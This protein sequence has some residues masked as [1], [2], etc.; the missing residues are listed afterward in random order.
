M[1]DE[2]RQDLMSIVDRLTADDRA[3]IAGLEESQ[4]IRLHMGLGMAIRNRI[5]AGALQALFRWS[6][7][8]VPDDVRHFD[9]VTWPI[10]LEVWRTVRIPA[11]P[12]RQ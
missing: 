4:V 7:S 5:R 3:Y 6:H 12:T 1:D 11:G 10:V 2:A 9:D 8:Q